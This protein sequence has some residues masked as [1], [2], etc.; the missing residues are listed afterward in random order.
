MMLVTGRTPSVIEGIGRLVFLTGGG[1]LIGLAIE[2][3]IDDEVM[4]TLQRELDLTESCMH[5]G[6][7][8]FD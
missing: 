2:G 4:R 8:L 1:V 7:H 5:S 3:Q 6:S